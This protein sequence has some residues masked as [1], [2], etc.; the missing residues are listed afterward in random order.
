MRIKITG[1]LALTIIGGCQHQTGNA[2][3]HPS[4]QSTRHCVEGKV[5]LTESG[6]IQCEE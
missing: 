3:V 5:I 1:L 6:K 2:H 4:E